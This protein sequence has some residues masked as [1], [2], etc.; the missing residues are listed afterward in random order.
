MQLSGSTTY[1]RGRPTHDVGGESLRRVVSSELSAGRP[2]VLVECGS[3]WA[4]GSAWGGDV[5][6]G[7]PIL[8]HPLLSYS[9]DYQD[10]SVVDQEDPN[11]A[12]I[13]DQW[14]T[15]RNA[16]AL[17]HAAEERFGRQP[18]VV[19]DGADGARGEVTPQQWHALAA[20]RAEAPTI[21]ATVGLD[22]DLAE[23]ARIAALN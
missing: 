13:D 1:E 9:D 3:Q 7:V 19:I 20:S 4:D 17:A 10:S 6:D 11:W 8:S 2:V 14:D 22:E 18:T 23:V 5:L 21:L 16:M 15:I 12:F